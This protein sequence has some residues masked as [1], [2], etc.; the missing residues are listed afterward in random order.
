[1]KIEQDPNGYLLMSSF[2]SASFN[3]Q[4]EKVDIKESPILRAAYDPTP[5]DLIHINR[6]YYYGDSRDGVIEAAPKLNDGEII[7]IG[8]YFGDKKPK[9][10]IKVSSQVGCPSKCDFCEIGEERLK[11]NLNWEEIFQQ[12]LAMA[13]VSAGFGIEALEKPH[14]VSFAGTGEPLS[15]PDIV[16]A[17]KAITTLKT[18]FKLS[19]VFPKGQKTID[20]LV[21][22]AQ[23]AST[24]SESTQLQIS[25]ISTDQEFRQRSAGKIAASFLEI[26]TGTDAWFTSF[27]K[28][29]K[30]NLSL[31][32]SEQTPAEAST[33]INLFPPDRFRFRFRSY[34]PTIN[35]AARGVKAISPERLLKIKED[36]RMYGYEVYDDATPTDTEWRF[37][38]ASNVTRQR[39]LMK[40]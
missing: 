11:R 35:G 18:S 20:R 21:G 17:F 34:V 10:I 7:E 22:I 19:T 37:S 39:E 31:I 25:L 30:I 8:Y 15:N 24:L 16:K 4:L 2:S 13:Q 32:L 40:Q 3:P 28:S 33:V 9:S 5:T 6:A 38:L 23:V 1:M 36:F 27:P 14:K 12:V 29:R 26:K